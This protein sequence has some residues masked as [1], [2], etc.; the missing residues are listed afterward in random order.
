[1][2]PLRGDLSAQGV[3]AWRPEIERSPL[4]GSSER[5]QFSLEQSFTPHELE[6]RVASTSFVAALPESDRAAFVGRVR[7]L[8]VALPE[9]FAFPYRTD[10]FLL[11]RTDR[12]I[13]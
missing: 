3:R 6:E 11:E 7:G 13:E 8:T 9:P 1:M 4:F 10:V 2:P 5:A 12:S